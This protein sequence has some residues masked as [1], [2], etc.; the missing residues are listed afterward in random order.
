MYNFGQ[1]YPKTDT[2]IKINNFILVNQI[3]LILTMDNWRASNI[4]IKGLQILLGSSLDAKRYQPKLCK[5]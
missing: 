2:V 5:K 1:K 4:I 3:N